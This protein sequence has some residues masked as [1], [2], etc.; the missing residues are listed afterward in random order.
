MDKLYYFAHPYT[1]DEANNY[2]LCCE[3]TNRLL[4][5]GYHVFSPIV[6]SHP[7]DLLQSRPGGEW[8]ELDEKI[9]K[10]CDGLILAPH[11]GLSDGCRQEFWR[12]LKA[13]QMVLFYRNIIRGSE[14]KYEPK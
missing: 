7:L 8:L 12:A 14:E 6:H 13:G 9:L 3:H 11:W 5:L 4:D 2:T 10:C 1:G